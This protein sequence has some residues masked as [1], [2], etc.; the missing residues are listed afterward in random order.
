D[1]DDDQ[2]R[3]TQF[4]PAGE[5]SANIGGMQERPGAVFTNRGYGIERRCGHGYKVSVAAGASA[6]PS[7]GSRFA[8]PSGFRLIIKA[9]SSAVP[10]SPNIGFQAG[11]PL[12]GT[13]FW[14]T[15]RISA[16][17]FPCSHS[18]SL[19]L[20]PIAPLASAPWQAAQLVA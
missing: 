14:M 16:G 8:K 19:R 20:G 15:L 5:T 11:I 1:V 6:L 18:L 17:R 3:E 10:V 4:P 7:A 13:P 9:V 2:Q 12:A